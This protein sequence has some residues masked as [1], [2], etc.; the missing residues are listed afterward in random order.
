MPRKLNPQVT[1][2]EKRVKPNVFTQYWALILTFMMAAMAN[3]EV[4][5]S[6]PGPSEVVDTFTQGLRSA[7]EKHESTIK[8]DPQAYYDE[9]LVVMEDA[10]QFKYIAKGVMGSYAK[11]ATKEQKIEFLRV[12][13]SKLAETLAKAIA[14]YSD[15]EITIEKEMDD[16][17]NARKKYVAQKIAGPDGEIKV[18]YTLGNWKKTGWRISNLT[19]DSTN[20]GET[21]KSQFEQSVTMN[22]GDLS[23]AIAWWI[24]NG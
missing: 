21:Y 10:I 15:A 12:F 19:M 7:L 5:P 22:K 2:L 11:T 3:A 13:K 8:E 14:N 17:K 4:A 18:V 6:G 1:G 23:K 9:V 24:D 20:L 16:D